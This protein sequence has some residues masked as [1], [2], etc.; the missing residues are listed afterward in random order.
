M[1]NQE[2]SREISRSGISL[3][4]FSILTGWILDVLSSWL[5]LQL[6]GSELS[7]FFW[8]FPPAW[9]LL[10]MGLAALTYKWKTPGFTVRAWILLLICFSSMIP[11]IRNT[12]LIL[13]AVL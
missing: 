8:I 6:G 2:S 4:F 7:P 1:E 10:F 11:G 9:M 3:V 12:V 13:E 5:G